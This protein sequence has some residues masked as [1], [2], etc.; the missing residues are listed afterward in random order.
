M[1]APRIVLSGRDNARAYR[2]EVNIAHELKEIGI[3]VDQQ[4]FISSLEEVSG[5]GARII[6]PLG[7]PQGEILHNPGERDVIHLHNQMEM[8]AHQAEGMNTA[9]E[10][11]DSMLEDQIEAI[12][13]AIVEEDRIASVAAEDD[14]IESGRVMDAKSTGHAGIIATN[15]RKSNLTP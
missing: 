7:E 4:G 5:P 13:V 1:T 2:I 10:F 12:T 11:L 14:V 3:G 8:V 6:D 9:M 15:V